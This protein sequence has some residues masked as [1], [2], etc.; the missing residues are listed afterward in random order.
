LKSPADL[1][2][3]QYILPPESATPYSG[4]ITRQLLAMAEGFPP[5]Q[6]IEVKRSAIIEEVR[7]AQHRGLRFHPAGIQSMN[8]AVPPIS[9]LKS[10]RWTTL[11]KVDLK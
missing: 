8:I 2:R 4:Q 6:A 5:S 7:C 10:P 11:P 3:E 1:A 9:P